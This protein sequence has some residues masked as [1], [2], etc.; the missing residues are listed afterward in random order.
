[1]LKSWAVALLGACMHSLCPL[2]SADKHLRAARFLRISDIVWSLPL[3]LSSFHPPLPPSLSSFAA[4]YAMNILSLVALG[5]LGYHAYE[6]YQRSITALG[7][8]DLVVVSLEVREGREGG[9][10]GYQICATVV[11]ERSHHLFV[12]LLS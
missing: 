9:R 3:P 11:A 8:V 12:I 6:R 5:Y 1:M 10:V 4:I 7:P 2:H